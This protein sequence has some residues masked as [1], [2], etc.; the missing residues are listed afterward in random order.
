MAKE[1]IIRRA[2]GSDA[3]G[4]LRLLGQIAAFH[5]EGR[6]DV[7]KANSRKYT[8]GQFEE[9]LQDEK[10]PVFVAVDENDSVLGYVFCM[11]M[12]LKEQEPFH[13]YPLLYIDDFC[14]DQDARGQNIGR[15]L[16]EAVKIHAHETGLKNIELNVWE[17]NEGAVKFYEKCGFTTQRRRME[18]IL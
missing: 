15:R 14:V 4:V 13:S 1:I 8:K 5:H 6:P 2:L 17:F 11:L 18:L 3:E 9:I 12:E 10:R 16:F 7:F